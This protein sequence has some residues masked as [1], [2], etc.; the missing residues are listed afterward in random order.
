MKGGGY[1]ASE[2]TG[3]VQYTFVRISWD[4][5]ETHDRIKRYR[6]T[7]TLPSQSMKRPIVRAP[8]SVYWIRS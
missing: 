4:K 7:A 1:E 3:C 2:W 6:D 8:S 5:S